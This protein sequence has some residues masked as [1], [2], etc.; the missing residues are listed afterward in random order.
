MLFNSPGSQVFAEYRMV[1]VVL[2][3]AP[4]AS[5]NPEIDY[6]HRLTRNRENGLQLDAQDLRSGQFRKS[7]V[8][9]RPEHVINVSGI[10]GGYFKQGSVSAILCESDLDFN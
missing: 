7:A 5:S 4:P 1:A 10:I 9:L 3:C 6:F 8:Q 2:Q